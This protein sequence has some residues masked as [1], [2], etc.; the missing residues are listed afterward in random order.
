M[1]RLN[2][3]IRAE[4]ALGENFC[5]SA[6]YFA[7]LDKSSDNWNNLW[8]Y[9]LEPLLEEYVRGLPESR[10]ILDTFC[11]A[12]NGTQADVNTTAQG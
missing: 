8:K 2:V 4:K 9:H 1:N 6:A 5:I 7:K 10:I 11:K 3:A 12:Y